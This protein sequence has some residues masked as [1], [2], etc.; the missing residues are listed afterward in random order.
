[1]KSTNSPCYGEVPG[2]W[3]EIRLKYVA[4]FGPSKEGVNELHDRNEAV[5]FLPMDRISEKGEVDKEEQ[6]LISTVW[7]GFTFCQDGDVIVAKITPCFENGKGA[8]LDG[9]LNG[10]AFASTEFYVLRPHHQLDGK[11]LYYLTYMYP[12]RDYGKAQMQGAAGQQRVPQRMIKDLF[13]GLPQYSEQQTI[14]CFLDH[15]IDLIDQYI[16]NKKKQIE[17]L[18]KLR[19]SIIS[20]AVTKGLDPDVEMMDSGSIWLDKYPTHWEMKRLKFSVS[21]QKGGVIAG[22]FGTQLKTS[23]IA[24]SGI[25]VYNQRIVIDR[26]YSTVNNFVTEKKAEELSAFSTGPGDLLISSRGTIGRCYLLPNSADIGV[27]HPCLLRVRPDRRKMLPEYLTIVIQDSEYVRTQVAVKSNATTIEV[28]YAGTMKNIE[29][30]VPPIDEQLQIIE[31][32]TEESL[33]INGA[34][35]QIKEQIEKIESYRASLISEAVTGKIDVLR[36]FNSEPPTEA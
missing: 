8:L 13:I 16:A 1:M 27:I 19:T 23:E 32:I 15:K 14:A 2:E 20:K 28:I 5:T 26:D 29:L 7:G 35:S 6:A 17:L 33:K 24:T 21:Q 9:L 10:V 18:E 12:F 4:Q 31:R 22:P 30:P 3:R 11:Y 36:S 25:R 34:I